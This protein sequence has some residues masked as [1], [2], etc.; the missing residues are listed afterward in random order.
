MAYEDVILADGPI[1]Y[2]RGQDTTGTA[3]ADASPTGLP[4][5]YVNGVVLDD[6]TDPPAPKA[7]GKHWRLDGT[8][9]HLL[10][11]TGTWLDPSAGFSIEHWFYVRSWATWMRLFD[12]ANAASTDD[13]WVGADNAGTMAA[14]VSAT[15]VVNF[16]RPATGAWFHFVLTC[17]AA[18]VL[19]VY[20]NGVAVGTVTGTP[21]AAGARAYKYIGRSAYP[22]PYLAASGTQAVIYPAA[23][24]AAQVTAHYN[25]GLDLA[26][27]AA[28]TVTAEGFD[29]GAYASWNGIEVAT[30]YQYRVNGGAPVTVPKPF[31]SITGLTNDTPVTVEVR[32]VNAGSTGAWSAP[33]S[34]TPV[35]TGRPIAFRSTFPDATTFKQNWTRT[36]TLTSEVIGGKVS[37]SFAQRGGYYI[38]LAD[39]GLASSAWEIEVQ[40]TSLATNGSMLGPWAVDNNGNGAAASW[41]NNGVDF[42][43]WLVAGWAYSNTAVGGGSVGAYSQP[44]RLRLRK[45]GTSYYARVSRDAGATWG[46]EITWTNATVV[47]RI[48]FGNIY[49]ASAAEIAAVTVWSPARPA[50][51]PTGL[52]TLA[53]GTAVLATWTKSD[54]STT[55]FDVRVNGGTPVSTTQQQYVLTGLTAGT[56]VTIEVRETNA[57]G[58]GPWSAPVTATPSGTLN[59][60][61]AFS[62]PDSTTSLGTADTG[63][64]WT[65]VAG[66]WGITNGQGYPVTS[67]AEAHAVLTGITSGDFDLTFQMNTY[68]SENDVI[69]RYAD[70]N[71][72]SMVRLDSATQIR[73]WQRAGGA[74][75]NFLNLANLPALATPPQIRLIGKGRNLYLYRN[76]VLVATVEDVHAGNTAR[77][78]FGLRSPTNTAARYDY[79]VIRDAPATVPGASTTAGFR[80][81]MGAPAARQSGLWVYKGR[82]LKSADTGSK[83]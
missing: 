6:T 2:S 57:S 32:A 14:R 51:S 3:A 76:G 50:T 15:A 11:P 43:G 40:M 70:Q 65:P 72:Q 20:V 13:I 21:P 25:A 46:P 34:V 22:D 9:D 16:P 18:G 1:W 68:G 47:T 12:F 83:P 62:R 45:N 29:L 61:D 66:T 37:V 79:L 48:G 64:A 31:V 59:V 80:E 28:P 81:H 33:V 17:T 69:Y 38:P 26:A 75:V 54:Q 10:L 78:G 23:L 19:T 53:T 7:L 74:W 71:N 63:Q 24:S 58:V 56:P 60:A 8:N 4:G 5:T 52:N 73:L 82:D 44:S 55:S 77:A 67:T 27:Y 36:G 41:Y 35:G 49:T 30:S 42:Y 39:L